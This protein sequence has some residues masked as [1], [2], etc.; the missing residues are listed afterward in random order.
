M[1]DILLNMAT[2]CTMPGCFGVV[3]SKRQGC[4]NKAQHSALNEARQAP[5]HT[6]NATTMVFPVQQTA[7]KTCG[8]C[9]TLFTGRRCPHFTLHRSAQPGMITNAIRGECVTPGCTMCAAAL[10]PP[11]VGQ[12]GTCAF[13]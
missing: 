6:V 11:Q 5:M 9:K 2:Q 13:N 3:N 8:E 4:T 1:T 7:H 10:S 12:H